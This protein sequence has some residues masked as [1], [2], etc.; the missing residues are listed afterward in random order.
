MISGSRVSFFLAALIA[1]V[2]SGCGVAEV[3]ANHQPGELTRRQAAGQFVCHEQDVTV[4]ELGNAEFQATGCGKTATWTCSGDSD[5]HTTTDLLDRRCHRITDVAN[6][7]CASS[8]PMARTQTEATTSKRPFPKDD[9]R[10]ALRA[11]ARG[12]R[13]CRAEGSESHAFDAHLRFEP[14]GRV[15]AV[16]LGDGSAR[17]PTDVA[18]CVRGRLAEVAL[19]AFDGEPVTVK[20]RV[21][22]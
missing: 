8:E 2:L 3:A 15:T 10:T 4:R 11:A 18:S 20:M 1:T 19:T 12:V 21:D 7:W 22:L 16:A 17:V 13:V 14:S 5:G 9:A 6:Q